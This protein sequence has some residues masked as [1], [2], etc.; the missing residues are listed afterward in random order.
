MTI[1][2]VF[3]VLKC[4]FVVTNSHDAPFRASGTFSLVCHRNGV[5]D[6]LAMRFCVLTKSIDLT[7]DF[8]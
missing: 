4:S 7:T 3:L 6:N 2:L 5:F 1:S 8:V